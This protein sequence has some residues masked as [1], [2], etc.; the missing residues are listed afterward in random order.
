MRARITIGIGAS[1]II[2]F[3]LGGCR[4]KSNDDIWIISPPASLE[5]T[6]I[7]R[8]GR[9]VIPNG[10][11]IRPRGRQVEVAPHPYGLVLSPDESIAV[12]ANCGVRP[13]SVSV[14]SDVLGE[15]PAVRQIPK[16]FDTDEGVLASVFMGLAVSADNPTL[17]IGG[18]QEGQ[19][20]VMDLT[21]DTR[22]SG[23]EAN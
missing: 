7:D 6:K 2:G 1:L 19:V 5:Q 12:T 18:G 9:T 14:I 11:V 22:T 16:G 13:F 3:F 15:T 17:Y 20:V 8:V 23:I 4:Q 10:R 21:Q